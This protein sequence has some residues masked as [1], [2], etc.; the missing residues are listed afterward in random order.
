[1]GQLY[2]FGGVGLENK[3]KAYAWYRI[4][5]EQGH[6]WAVTPLARVE[7][8]LKVAGLWHQGMKEYQA[9]H[10]IWYGSR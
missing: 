10:K 5:K 4:A 3:A 8:Q 2:E 6:G 9:V 7:Q 1:L